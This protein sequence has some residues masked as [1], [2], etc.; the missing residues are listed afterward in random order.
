M[1]VRSLNELYD[2]SV[3]A[4][5]QADTTGYPSCNSS[6]RERAGSPWCF[7]ATHVDA[8]SPRI[9]LLARRSRSAPVPAPGSRAALRAG[10]RRA[11]RRHV[12]ARA[13]T[14]RSA[15]SV[16]LSRKEHSPRLMQ[17]VAPPDFRSP[18]RQ[19]ADGDATN[20]KK[21]KAIRHPTVLSNRGGD[22]KYEMY[23]RTSRMRSALP[24]R[25][26]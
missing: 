2:S 15:L 26:S 14:S 8:E 12:R 21:D 11:V 23:A 24:L 16:R 5:A 10:V 25:Q 1:T 3:H 18:F 22:R 7:W 6:S 13:R 9:R 20:D 19:P 17:P 4:P